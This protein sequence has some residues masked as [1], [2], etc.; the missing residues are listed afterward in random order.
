MKKYA[1][2]AL[3]LLLCLSITLLAAC[4]GQKTEPE[5]SSLPS[6]AAPAQSA[7][8]G[9]SEAQQPGADTGL[10][11]DKPLDITWFVPLYNSNVLQNA[12]DQYC[13]QEIQKRTGINIEFIHPPVGSESDTFNVRVASNDLT[14]IITWEWARFTG[15]PNKAIN[16]DIIIDLKDLA[17]QYAPDYTA[18][19]DSIPAARANATLDDGS[20]YGFI[21]AVP[22][23]IINSTG[24]FMIRRDWLD[25]LGL[26]V[27]E[28]IEDWYTVLKAFKEKDPNGNGQPD[29]IPF[30]AQKGGATSSPNFTCFATAWGIRDGYFPDPNQGG[31]IAYGPILPQF[32]EFLTEMAKWYAEG[33]IDPEFPTNARKNIDEKMTTEVAGAI[34]GAIGS[35]LGSYNQTGKQQNPEFNLVGVAN[36]KAE[37]GTVYAVQDALLQG[38]GSQS[39]AVT[40]K[41]QYAQQ[42]VQ[43]LNYLYSEEGRTLM[44]WGKEG[45]SYEV[46]DGKP[47]YTEL[48]M[49]NP[50]GKTKLDAAAA[51]AVPIYGYF[52]AFYLDSFASI[53]LSTPQQEEAAQLWASQDTSICMPVLYPNEEEGALISKK[54]ADIST[55]VAET[56]LKFVIGKESLDNFDSYVD[57]IRQ[58]GVDEMIATYQQMYDRYL[59][60]M[61]Q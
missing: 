47:R 6:Q 49:N 50:E 33:L 45:E 24:G 20:I 28:T 17:A 38:I 59:R 21:H 26:S 35:Q 29:E 15:G 25:K 52:S 3:S 1:K 51:Y 10:L 23:P 39:S 19:I 11:V 14:D 46:V 12:G 2:T 56:V 22:D 7:A 44:N 42:S 5:S 30:T 16:D 34:Y 31:K 27:P 4:S 55:Y 37:N 61:A 36:P 53:N 43:L 9:S 18:L 41:N 57:N 13:W 54:G 58:M 48:I 40:T 8:A 60:K 32:R